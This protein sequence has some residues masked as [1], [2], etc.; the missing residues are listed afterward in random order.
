MSHS[1]STVVRSVC[2]LVSKLASPMF[3]SC[4]IRYTIPITG[5][6]DQT[7]GK[8]FIR[9]LWRYLLTY[10]ILQRYCSGILRSK[11]NSSPNATWNTI[12]KAAIYFLFSLRLLPPYTQLSQQHASIIAERI[13]AVVYMFVGHA[14]GSGM[15]LVTLDFPRVMYRN[16]VC[17]YTVTY[18][19]T[20]AH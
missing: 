16:V 8:R 7:C 13:S 18:A 14:L 12:D 2:V 6:A 3:Y 9:K 10:S 5:D 4:Q 1:L 15:S 11:A 20:T 19:S 17:Y